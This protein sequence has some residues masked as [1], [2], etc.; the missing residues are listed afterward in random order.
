[1][2]RATGDKEERDIAIRRL[3]ARVRANVAAD[4][5]IAESWR[6]SLGDITI[7]ELIEDGRRY[8]DQPNC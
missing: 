8:S 1:M 3:S 4:E 5:M 2:A 6:H 7:R